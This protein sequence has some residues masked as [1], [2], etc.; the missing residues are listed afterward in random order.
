MARLIDR[1]L[2]RHCLL[3]GLVAGGGQLCA[4]CRR[5]LP[6]TG[7]CCSLCALPLPAGGYGADNRTE[8]LRCGRCLLR[9][10][11]WDDAVA[12]LPYLYPA[13]RVVCR[14]KF[15]RD[16]CCGAVLAQALLEEIRRRDGPLPDAI[17][18]V[19]LHRSRYFARTFNQA[20]LLARALGRDL[21]IPVHTR[22]LLRRRR[23]RA[24]SGLDAAARRRNVR[25]AFTVRPR[26]RR[27]ALA[28]HIALVDDVL[29]TGVTLTE[30]V[31][32]L[33]RSGAARV[34]VWVAA[35]APPP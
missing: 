11:P 13:D 26:T 19:P 23:T 2:P 16:L 34:T 3:C 32:T 28:R 8:R 9:P 22:L 31:R 17:V 24:Q 35:R 18:P 15:G 21:H 27:P 30:C 6:R 7:P 1:L 33:K 4:A 5:D 10:P 14:F 29:T 25:G 12:A 20:E